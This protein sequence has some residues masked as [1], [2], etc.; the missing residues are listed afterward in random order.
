[1]RSARAI[2]FCLTAPARTIAALVAR[3][4]C[5]GSRGGSTATRAKSRPAGRAPDATRS[6]SADNRTRRKSPK[7]LVMRVW[8]YRSVGIEQAAVLV[9]GESI[10]H[11]GQVIGDDARPLGF[12]PA[13]QRAPF[14]G[15]AF[16]P[17]TEQLEQLSY[18]PER[19]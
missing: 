8:S 15:Q 9:E 18:D 19:L 16:G 13:G 5:A 17:G 12:A 7:M 10:G 2:G 11:A 14:A 3:S 1:M 4:P 6:S